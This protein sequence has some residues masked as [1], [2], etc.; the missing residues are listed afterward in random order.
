MKRLLVILTGLLATICFLA[1]GPVLAVAKEK[2]EQKVERRIKRKG[3]RRVVRRVIVKK[4]PVKHVK[5]VVVHKV[6]RP[7]RVVVRRRRVIVHTGPTVVKEV[8]V[9]ERKRRVVV[10]KH[11][12]WPRRRREDSLLGVGIRASAV[13]VEGEKL[14][15]ATVEN[16]TMAGLGLQLRGKVSRHIGLEL[17]ID[18]LTGSND[19]M[20]QTTIPIMLSLM[21]YVFPRS[22][23]RPYGLL[24]GG[25]H[26]TK[27]EYDIGFRHDLV[28]LAGQA[29][30]GIEVRLS[31]DFSINADL[32]FL[33]VYKNLGSSTTL[34]N[35]CISSVNQGPS[36][37]HN[38][39]TSDKFNLGAQVFIGANFYF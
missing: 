18:Y 34:R 7:R 12:Y 9:V 31:R 15:L 19:E 13:T 28:E 23:L 17:G 30:G 33:G 10:E 1:A 6:V 26:L 37:C 38:I 27:L 20:T 39:N 29:G 24:G 16:P 22:R 11:P 2:Q 36:A 3:R 5:A 4:K 25:V 35:R 32:R 14:N 21:Y 8:T